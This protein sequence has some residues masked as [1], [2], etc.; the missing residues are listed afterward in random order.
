M[1]SHLD[2]GSSAI[3]GYKLP[4]LAKEHFS[5]WGQERIDY[6][7][8]I[9]DFEK[10]CK[11]STQPAILGVHD[12]RNLNLLILNIY[13]QSFISSRSGSIEEGEI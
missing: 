5:Y 13:L 10:G 12:V 3:G 4:F 9:Q 7:W 1:L 8:R 11:R 6:Q 2:Y